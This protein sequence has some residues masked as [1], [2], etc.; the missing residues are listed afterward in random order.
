MKYCFYILWAICVL[1]GVAFA[2]LL[3][4]HL[5]S[6]R[7]ASIASLNCAAATTNNTLTAGVTAS[8]VTCTV[9]YT[10]GTGGPY[11]GQAVASTGILGLTATLLPGNFA[12]GSGTLTYAITGTPV[13][14]GT[15]SFALGIGGQSCT[16][17]LVVNSSGVP[18]TGVHTCGAV[19]VH[20]SAVSYG[21]L[22]DQGGNVYKTVVIGSQEWMAE[23][24]NTSVYRNGEPIVT[25]LNAAGWSTTN[26][27]AWCHY[28][29]DPS[30]DCP[31]GKSYNWF[32]CVDSRQLC[33][34]GWH[35]PSDNEF[36]TLLNFL[37]PNANGGVSANTAGAALKSAG[38]IVQGDGLWNYSAG[39][40]GTNSTGFSA[41]PASF[42][43]AFSGN[44]T[45]NLGLNAYLWTATQDNTD[46]TLA[47]DRNM[48]NTSN[49]A[50]RSPKFKR[51]GF[52]VRC[53]RDNGSFGAINSLDCGSAVN[54]GTLTQNLAA[55]S[56]SSIVP[57]TGG[58][59]GFYNT[60][61]TASTGVTGL[62]AAVA[63]G[64]FANGAGSLTYTI[65]GTPSGSG[66]ASFALNM[67]GTTCTLT[68]VV[69]AQVLVGP[70]ACGANYVHNPALTY[71]TVTDQ[72]G[73]TYKTIVIGNKEWMAENLKTYKYR[74]GDAIPVVSDN[75]GWNLSLLMGYSCF[76]EN[77]SL[78]R[79]C[80]YGKFYNHY[81]VADPRGLCPTGWHVPDNSE[82]NSLI[83]SLNAAAGGQLKSAG[84]IEGLNGY[85]YAPNTNATNSTG[86]SGLP[87][88]YRFM[89]GVFTGLGYRGYW[90]SSQVGGTNAAG[91]YYLE[92][93]T[94]TMFGNSFDRRSGSSVR[95]VRD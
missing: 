90:W 3:G 72:S 77:D 29:D 89:N 18:G 42:R 70:H 94:D 8:G 15:A 86:F 31:Y 57:Y 75:S 39:T 47:L 61:I 92:G 30:Y 82:W 73:Y 51:S 56:V 60:S 74:N 2:Q 7:S 32:A 24:L 19:N 55:L 5:K 37:D 33:P 78:N 91:V 27:G 87:G 44:F 10:G 6:G 40:L 20:N 13:I 12:N 79:N 22:T 11:G 63:A 23:N 38:S 46:P 16:L 45:Q 59:G 68:R 50:I 88:G 26:L 1:P 67:G 48:A 21:S 35:V 52:S 17:S 76:V 95:C 54:S 80:P 4:G 71:G 65:T 9:P 34:S 81:A 14:A 93:N 83:L 41:L 25:G 43:N 84:T 85:W 49:S 64:N 28:L 62:F 36:S 53:I 66:T 69:A 58:N